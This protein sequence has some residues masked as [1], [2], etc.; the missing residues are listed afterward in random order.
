MKLSNIVLPLLCVAF[1]LVTFNAGTAVAAGDDWRPLDP[2]ELAMKTSAV[3]K[4]AD[5]EALFW[6]VRLDDSQLDEFSLKHYVRIK[7]FTER[8]KDSQSKVDL[9]F[10]VPSTETFCTAFSLTTEAVVFRGSDSPRRLPW[11]SN[12]QMR[13][14]G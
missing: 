8:G 7:V 13:S 3:E 1:C 6:E 4:D 9:P 14:S 5:A 10:I 2:A 11:Q 12:F